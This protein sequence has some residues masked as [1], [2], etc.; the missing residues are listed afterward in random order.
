MIFTRLWKV[1]GI[2]SLLETMNEWLL[3]LEM[4]Y[5]CFTVSKF[6]LGRVIQNVKLNLKFP[7]LN[8]RVESESVV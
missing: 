5:E 3:S 2:I 6:L 8:W 1:F 7:K 4:R